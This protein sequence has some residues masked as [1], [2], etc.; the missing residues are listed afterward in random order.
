M[1]PE[2]NIIDGKTYELP[3]S[4]LDEYERLNNEFHE[5]IMGTECLPIPKGRLSNKSNEPLHKVWREYRAKFRDLLIKV[6]E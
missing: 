2:R 1:S 4:K 5:V 6:D 3:D